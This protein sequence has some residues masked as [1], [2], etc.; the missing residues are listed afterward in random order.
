MLL[1]GAT[2]VEDTPENLSASPIKICALHTL[3]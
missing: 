3:H 2:E 1:K